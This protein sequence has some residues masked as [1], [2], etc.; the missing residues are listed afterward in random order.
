[1]N[2][3]LLLK[4]KEQILREP[5][6]FVMG[7][8]F[9]PFPADSDG[10]DLWDNIKVPNCGTAACIAGWA[11]ALHEGKAPSEVTGAIIKAE[12]YL[13]KAENYLDIEMEDA[14]DLFYADHW[15]NDLQDRWDFAKSLEERAQIAAE[16]IDQF[17]AER[18]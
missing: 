18:S 14:E 8:W 11:I 12:N 3:E 7:T 9:T 6:Q 16:R 2:K 5:K 4:I 10:G 1:M 15:D 17:I 13:I